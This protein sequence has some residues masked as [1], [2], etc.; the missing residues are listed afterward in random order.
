MP[1][2]KRYPPS[3]S[4][5]HQRHL[6]VP[7]EISLGV[8]CLLMGNRKPH[9]PRIEIQ[10]RPTLEIFDCVLVVS[11]DVAGRRFLLQISVSAA[12]TRYRWAKYLR[13]QTRMISCFRCKILCGVI[14]SSKLL[15]RTRSCKAAFKC[16]SVYLSIY[17][18]PNS[19]SCSL[20]VAPSTVTYPKRLLSGRV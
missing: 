12:G 19:L 20:L 8:L 2:N 14:C 15:G 3:S 4:I 5:T 1:V 18:Y 16:L 10:G 9:H 11:N 6:P 17:C 7:H 13:V